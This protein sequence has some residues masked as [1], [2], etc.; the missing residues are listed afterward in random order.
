MGVLVGRLLK[1]ALVVVPSMAIGVIIGIAA[2]A[3]FLGADGTPLIG[4]ETMSGRWIT[5]FDSGTS[6]NRSALFDEEQLRAPLRGGGAGH[7]ER[8]RAGHA[9]AAGQG[10]S[11]ASGIVIDTEMATCSRTITW[12]R[13]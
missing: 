6:Y 8:D 10:T 13:V 4:G 11:S 7:R 1:A 5:P 9:E 3:G 2:Q 12:S